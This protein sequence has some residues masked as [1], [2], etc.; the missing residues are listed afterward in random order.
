MLCDAEYYYDSHS[1][2]E[3]IDAVS[4]HVSS[5]PF[6][7]GTVGSYPINPSF[8]SV[9]GGQ[10]VTFD[11]ENLIL[12]SNGIDNEVPSIIIDGIECTAVGFTLEA[13]PKLT[14]E[15]GRRAGLYEEDKELEILFSVGYAVTQGYRYTY[16]SLWSSES[17]WGGLFAPVDGESVV[18][19]RGTHLLFDEAQS[20]KLNLV[21]I[22]GG[23][24][25][26]KPELDPSNLNYDRHFDARVIFVRDGV[27][28]AGTETEPYTSKLT[29]TLTGKKYDPAIPTYGNK[30][31]G[32]RQGSIDIHGVERSHTW[33][34]L[35][36]TAAIGATSIV[37]NEAVDW[38]A[39]EQIV[40]ASTG[41][42]WK[43]AEVR[44]ITSAVTDS[45]A[46][47]TTI[48]FDDG[49]QYSHYAGV[50]SYGDN[51]DQIEIRAE[52]GLLTRN[53]VFR[54]FKESEEDQYGA[55][56]MIHSMGDES[57]IGR[58]SYTEFTHVGQAF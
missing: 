7:A 1:V 21:L 47:T 18:V 19:P 34:H 39:P 44:N 31:I 5:T 25:I 3:D 14:C 46:G 50:D 23:S 40:I 43:Q 35:A 49:L 51:G 53:I 17:T 33:S 15:T 11:V 58:I 55:H 27:F 56:I 22:D 12:D 13:Q 8:G 30:V 24:L 4:Y 36:Q 29:I 54:G 38:E 6:L 32:V 57:S 28:E 10:T 45:S 48:T 20:P 37:L 9:E 41:F 2:L 42:D 26:F 52:V 16:A